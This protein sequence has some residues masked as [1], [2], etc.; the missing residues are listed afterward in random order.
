MVK[1]SFP[2]L[3]FHKNCQFFEKFQKPKT[4][5]FIYSLKKTTIKI[6]LFLNLV[7]TLDPNDF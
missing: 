5:G 7:N 1:Q 6:L 3:F 2:F 4:K